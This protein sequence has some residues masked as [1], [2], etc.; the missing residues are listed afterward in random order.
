M[1]GLGLERERGIVTQPAAVAGRAVGHRGYSHPLAGVRHVLCREERAVTAD[2]R[3]NFG[4]D[5]VRHGGPELRSGVALH[6]GQERRIGVR[7]T[8]NPVELLEHGLNIHQRSRI[9]QTQAL[10]EVRDLR[11]EELRKPSPPGQRLRSEFG[12]TQR[13]ELA[14]HRK[15]D[16]PS[17]LLADRPELVAADSDGASALEGLP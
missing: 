11:V 15:S 4:S 1:Y 9:A 2:G 13:L 16:L 5:D 10:F 7:G 17:A 6:D 12:T 3:E 8:Q 14:Y